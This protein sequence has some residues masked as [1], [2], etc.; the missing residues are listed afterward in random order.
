M[1]P[2]LFAQKIIGNWTGHIDVNGTEL[3]MVCHF[4]KSSEGKIEGTWDSPKQKAFGLSFSAINVDDDSVHME[5]KNISGSYAGKFVGN[6]SIAGIWTQLSNHFPLNFSRS[7][8]EAETKINK[9][10][11]H[12]NEKEIEITSAGGSQLSGTLLSKNNQQKIAIIIAGS[13]Q[14]IEMET[15]PSAPLPMNTKCLLTI[16]ILK[17]SPLSGMINVV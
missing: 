10:P 4:N 14:R 11:V 17:I 16:W 2:S 15:A 3:P 6:D 13:G 1:Y 8:G 9:V 12:P 7:I 5:M